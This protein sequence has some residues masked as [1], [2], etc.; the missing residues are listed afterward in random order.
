MKPCETLFNDFDKKTMLSELQAKYHF[1]RF[2]KEKKNPDSLK[3]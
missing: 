3:A 2:R 1:M